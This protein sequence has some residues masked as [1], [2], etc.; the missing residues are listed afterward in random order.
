MVIYPVRCPYIAIVSFLLGTMLVQIP[1]RGVDASLNRHQTALREWD[2]RREAEGV[3]A[4]NVVYHCTSTGEAL[5]SDAHISVTH[6]RLQTYSPMKNTKK[7]AT[8]PIAKSDMP[9]MFISRRTSRPSFHD[10]IRHITGTPM[11]VTQKRI[12][13]SCWSGSEWPG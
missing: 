12:W 11:R 2:V 10:T 9:T 5:A 8:K 1:L 6:T 3:G 4:W 13:L 7:P